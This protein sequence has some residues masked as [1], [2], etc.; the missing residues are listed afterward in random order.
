MVKRRGFYNNG[1]RGWL[2]AAG[3]SDRY[4]PMIMAIEHSGILITADVIKSKLINIEIKP[5]TMTARELELHL[6][7]VI[8]FTLATLSQEKMLVHLHQHQTRRQ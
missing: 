8:N 3:S 7:R 5:E 1:R 6:P 2:S 4:T